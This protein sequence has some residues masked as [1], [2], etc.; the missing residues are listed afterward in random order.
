MNQNERKE[1]SKGRI[2]PKSE[3]AGRD[4]KDH[5]FWLLMNGSNIEYLGELT[6]RFVNTFFVGE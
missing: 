1:T 6:S 2:P 3:I 4:I 5:R